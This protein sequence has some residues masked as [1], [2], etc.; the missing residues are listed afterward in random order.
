DGSTDATQLHALCK[1]TWITKANGEIADNTRA[2]VAPALSVLLGED[3]SATSHDMLVQEVRRS[4]ALD[5]RILAFFRPGRP[6]GFVNF[7]GA[8]RNTSEDWLR[9][10]RNTVWS[11]FKL[12]STAGNDADAQEVYEGIESLPPLPR[13]RG[14]DL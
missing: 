12:A 4:G 13:A 3:F 9:E 5:D 7:Y 6:V 10:H 11:L 14:G 1:L 2:V 8:F